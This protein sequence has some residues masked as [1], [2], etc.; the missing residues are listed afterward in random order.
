MARA[1]HHAPPSP[2]PAGANALHEV[3]NVR[4]HL[5]WCDRQDRLGRRGTPEVAGGRLRR[6]LDGCLRRIDMLEGAR[7]HLDHQRGLARHDIG[8]V[9]VEGDDT[10]VSDHGRVDVLED[11]ADLPGELG[12]GGAGIATRR[13]R[14]G[15]GVVWLSRDHDFQPA[16]ADDAFD[17]G[18]GLAC[19]VQSRPLL[20]VDL[21]VAG[22]LAS[23]GSP[24]QGAAAAEPASAGDALLVVEADDLQARAC[25]MARVVERPQDLEGGHDSVRAIQA[26]PRGHGVGVRTDQ[27]PWSRRPGSPREH[28]V[29]FVGPR[30]QAGCLHP[31]TQPEAGLEVRRRAGDAVDATVGPAS[32]PAELAEFGEQALAGDFR[33]SGQRGQWPGE[34][35]SRSAFSQSARTGAKTSTTVAPS[36]PVEA[37]CGTSPWIEY[38]SPGPSCFAWPAITMVTL[39]STTKPS[40]SFTWWCSGMS[41]LGSRSI[42]AMVSRS[43]CTARATAPVQIWYGR[44]L[45]KEPNVLMFT[46]RFMGR[47]ASRT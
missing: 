40:C 42:R 9:W 18:D 41:R 35:S 4:V 7:P 33:P 24:C 27:Q 45:E 3:D 20:D 1:A 34:G 46:S 39:P 28:V 38:E 43:P 13:V 36:G 23:V 2:T 37:E 21:D 14:G 6:S 31:P 17:D 11:V 47:A 29:G 10:H 19:G 5:H 26:S 22:D 44:P 25:W 16:N 8:A 32:D 12:R 15:P 30:L